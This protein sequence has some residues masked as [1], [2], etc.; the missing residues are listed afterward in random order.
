MVAKYTDLDIPLT[1]DDVKQAAQRLEPYIR[2]TAVTTLSLP[3]SKQNV[4]VKMENLQITGSFK[5][6]G[7][8]NRV[9]NL[10]QEERMRGVLAASAGN[11]AQGVALAAEQC[12]VPCTI[13]MPKTA[14]LSKIAATRDLGANV[15]LYGEVYDEACFYAYS[16]AEKSGAV[17]IHPFND[18][19]V[20]AGQGTIGLE[21]LEKHPEIKQVIMP[22]GGGGLAAGI[23][24]TLK[25]I[26]PSI[27]VIGVEPKQAASMKECFSAN[28][29][30]TLATVSTMADGIA[31]K[32]PGELTYAIFRKH[33]DNI[34]TV[35]DGEIA[36]T[37]LYLLEKAK[38]V[39][40]GAGAAAIAAALS[41]K[42]DLS[43]PTMAVLSGGN[44]DVTM[45]ERI[46]DK[47]MAKQ[48]R[49]LALITF[50]PDKPGHLNRVLGIISETGANI[51]SIN[52]DRIATDVELGWSM[53]KF[54]LE[55]RDRNHEYEI[56]SAL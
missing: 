8:M 7:A 11:H 56:R 44:I 17:F 37:I 39:S 22:V 15:V 20:I 27:R 1:L 52:H 24:L 49:K 5:V 10:T 28:R 19:F 51:V 41:G 26:D 3:N 38:I 34:V 16:I 32:T 53:V 12:G 35:D 40:E 23:A 31:V 50:I 43:I 30:V 33:M 45:I 6:R 18:A 47:G 13:V 9:L 36:N 2:R 48:G 54:E 42:I 29:V 25:S 14:P 4:F 21:I 46:I 55:T